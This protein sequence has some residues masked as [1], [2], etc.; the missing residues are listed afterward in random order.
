MEEA[1][2]EMKSAALKP[3]T[4]LLRGK[5]GEILFDIKN[6]CLVLCSNCQVGPCAVF[7]FGRLE[8][9]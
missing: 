9:E 4:N 2:I 1:D 5:K 3:H 7:L 6:V 8:V